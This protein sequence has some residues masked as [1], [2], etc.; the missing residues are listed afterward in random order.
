MLD[1]QNVIEAS[2]YRRDLL[3]GEVEQDRMARVTGE[4]D[5]E[6]AGGR[7][8]LIGALVAAMLAL[9]ATGAIAPR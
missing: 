5:E 2:E 4:Y 9:V 6:H 8:S 1:W 3:L 7:P